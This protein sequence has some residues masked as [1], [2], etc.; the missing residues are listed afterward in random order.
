MEKIIEG[1][2]LIIK[3]QEEKIYSI[4]ALNEEKNSLENQIN[5]IKPTNNELISL[6]KIYHPYYADKSN[7]Q[8]RL[9]EINNL[10]N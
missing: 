7:L 8:V 2:N 4:E 6:G 3:T 5:L 9:D 1:D 10:L